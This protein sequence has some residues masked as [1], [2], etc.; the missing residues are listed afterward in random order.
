[1]RPTAHRI[2]VVL[3]ILALAAG[4]AWGATTKWQPGNLRPLIVGWEQFFRVQ[5]NTTKVGGQPAVEGYITNTWGFAATNVQ[6]LVRGFDGSGKMVGQLVAWGPKEVDPGGRVYFDVP[7][8]RAA[9]YEVAIFAWNWV[10]T[11][12]GHRRWR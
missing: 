1:M 10:Q 4:H 8:P 2:S 11:G 3:L 12:G 5:W 6:L 9:S 7:V